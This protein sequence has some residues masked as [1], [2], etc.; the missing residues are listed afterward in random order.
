MT[1]IILYSLNTIQLISDQASRTYQLIKLKSKCVICYTA[2][3]TTCRPDHCPSDTDECPCIGR[4]QGPTLSLGDYLSKS[5]V[6]IP[7][8]GKSC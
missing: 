3:H 5:K 8:D 2:N 7:L 4:V 6:A 1:L